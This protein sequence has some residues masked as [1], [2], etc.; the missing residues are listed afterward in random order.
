MHIVDS[1]V[2]IWGADTGRRDGTPLR[3][4]AD[5]RFGGARGSR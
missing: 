5:V 3:R 2:H 4:V 1:Q